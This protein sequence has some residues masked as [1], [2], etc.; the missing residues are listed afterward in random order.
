MITQ[1]I[2]Q[3]IKKKYPGKAIILDPKDN[4][5]EIVCEIEPT[6]DHPEKS[7]AI[8]VVGRSKPHYH[9]N[10]TEIYEAVKGELTVY[11]SGKKYVLKEGERLT[12]ETGEVHNVEGDEAWFMTYS[13]P[14]WRLDDHIVV[15]SS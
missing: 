8:A 2:I 11:K 4:P 9:K 5:T 3:E 15:D 12:I 6:T 10:S 1:K 14:G 13:A 7:I